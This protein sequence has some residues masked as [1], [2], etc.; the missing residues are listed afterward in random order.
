LSPTGINAGHL[1]YKGVKPRLEALKASEDHL[2]DEEARAYRDDAH[3]ALVTAAQ[4]GMRPSKLSIPN[5]AKRK[6]ALDKS[7]SAISLDARRRVL[8]SLFAIAVHGGRG[9]DRVKI[10]GRGVN[11]MSA[12]ED[13]SEDF[14]A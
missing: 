13:F 7:W 8:R 2:R 6:S 5:A 4:G 12:E 1:T 9:T 11:P 14:S 10:T 3:A